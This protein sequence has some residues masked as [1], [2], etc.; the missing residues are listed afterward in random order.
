MLNVDDVHL[1]EIVFSVLRGYSNRGEGYVTGYLRS[2]NIKVTRARIRASISRVDPMGIE[3]RKRKPIRRRQYT[4]DG[5]FHTWH[6]DG[7]HKLIRWKLV[8]HGCIDGFSRTIIYLHCAN[9]NRAN[10]VYEQYK[11]A[12]IEWGRFP[13][14]C[15][16]DKG[17]ENVRV[18]EL[19]LR[20]CGL[21]GFIAGPSTS[22]QRI[23]RFWRDNSVWV[24]SFYAEVFRALDKDYNIYHGVLDVDNTD[25]LWLLH[26][27]FIPRI[28][29]DLQENLGTWN[30]HS[31]RTERRSPLQLIELRKNY[32]DIFPLRYNEMYFANDVDHMNV[33]ANQHIHVEN[34]PCRLTE[35]ELIHFRALVQPFTL[36]TNYEDF[37]ALYIIAQDTL[38]GILNGDIQVEPQMDVEEEGV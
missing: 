23:E 24:I 22:N 27:L 6:I 29:E 7:C 2:H 9:N 1:D 31:I 34:V 19:M 16:S 15:R 36:E 32:F 12:I 38:E 21:D 11:N 4:S 18:A 14:R 26:Y 17:G 37:V 30:N 35:E 13:V 10:T 33:N 3:Y 8:I 20:H 5:P 25:D 28:N